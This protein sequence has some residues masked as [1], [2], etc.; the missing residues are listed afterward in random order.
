MNFAVDKGLISCDER[1]ATAQ[2]TI[3][4]LTLRKKIIM[5]GLLGREIPSG[6]FDNA[7]IR[8]K[9]KENT[10]K[11]IKM[12]KM[13]YTSIKNPKSVRAIYKK[14]Q[15]KYAE[16]MVESM[17]LSTQMVSMGV[18]DEGEHLEFCNGSTHQ[19]KYIDTMCSYGE[20]LCDKR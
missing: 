12:E 16:M 11:L 17:E 5:I 6:S 4:E 7:D 20:Y 8:I 13:I 1:I 15:D 9:N 18:V 14:L 3:D 19:K 10:I 2:R